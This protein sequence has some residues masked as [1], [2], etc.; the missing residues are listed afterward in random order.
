MPAY[1]GPWRVVSAEPV[2][3]ELLGL[4]RKLV[5][6]MLEV[7]GIPQR[8]WRL[9]DGTTIHAL[10]VNGMPKVTITHS[11]HGVVRE[12][13]DADLWLP[14]GFVVY[15]AWA[16][17]PYGVGLP[18]VPS[19]DPAVG[20]YDAANL[21]PG[22][23]RA[24]WTAGGPCGEVL[25]SMDE[26]AG[27]PQ[28]LT[29]PVPLMSDPLLGPVFRW[30]GRGSYDDRP[31]RS[32]WTSYRLELAPLVQHYSE[33]NV[34][35]GL[36]LFE[37]VN[38]ARTAAS[39]TPAVLRFRGYARPAEI[40]ASICFTAG[41]DD[42]TSTSYPLA[43]RHSYDRL[44][45]EGYAADVIGVPFVSFNRSDLFGMVEFR[46]ASGAPAD[47]VAAWASAPGSTLTSDL[48]R[49]V[50]ADVGY[51]GGFSA[52]ALSKVDRWIHAGNMNWQSSDVDLPALS[53]H[54]FAGLNLAW[55]TYPASYD[56]ANYTTTPLA[57]VRSF[58]DAQ[59]DCWLTYPRSTSPQTCDTEP[60]LGRHIYSRGRAIAMAP[61]GG[62]VWGACVTV[63]T[64][65][66][67]DVDRLIA[68]VHHPEEQPT[69]YTHEGFTRYLRVWWAD[70]PRRAGLRLAPEL[71]IAGE[72]AADPW[73]WHGGQ[74]IDVGMMS[75]PS[76]P[77]LAASTGVNSLKYA[78]QW[79]F[80]ADGLR[81]VCLRDYGA[82]VDYADLRGQAW[83]AA[84]LARAVELVFDTTADDLTTT[85]V[86]HDLTPGAS[87]AP[88][89]LTAL[90]NVGD[91]FSIPIYEMG[92]VPVAVDYTPD[93][94]LVYAYSAHVV[95][96][97]AAIYSPTDG[98][99]GFAE[100]IDYAYIG[101]GTA[102][103]KYMLDLSQRALHGARFQ[104]PTINLSHEL[105]V[106]LD[107]ATATFALKQTRP[108]FNINPS[109]PSTVSLVPSYPCQTFTA[110]AV[111][112]VRLARGG[113]IVS[114]AW[115]AA[116]DGAVWSVNDLCYPTS[117]DVT[118]LVYLPL[119]ASG[120][121]QG[122][123]AERHG[124]SVYGYQCS[125]IPKAVPALAAPPSASPCGCT[126]T[127]GDV[128]GA[129]YLTN[130]AL[131]P[132]GGRTVANV[133]LPDHDWLI[134]SKVV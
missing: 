2:P 111:N 5:G 129:P 33:E 130:A 87:A 55:E 48:G 17:Y 3:P 1:F 115:F 71:V 88:R 127:P 118:A 81:A 116:P 56:T 53:W 23:D 96:Q 107:V 94:A 13:A 40:A 16:G 124:R 28:A 31:A 125:P 123:Y 75:A 113:D 24:R 63:V 67:G 82:L 34:A 122:F 60:A 66:T 126:L 117:A 8:Q 12:V 133:P 61:R 114:E 109:S 90:P 76:D 65:A 103:V 39:Q 112:G 36:A 32:A 7:G 58:T 43:Y 57:P 83:S 79:R 27:Y 106:V 25:V 10:I 74:Q 84:R 121:V 62:L 64:T 29:V 120:H 128:A 73:A 30:A 72:D 42:E 134:Y 46:A 22:L 80:A 51:R 14:R 45:K 4:A 54:G 15:P 105:A 68:V 104:S 38:A 26:Q 9:D 131:N 99:A 37:A 11:V 77:T 89:A 101:T 35:T 92:A 132:R 69:D 86:F 95:S 93:G 21:S 20:P 85:V 110:G 52:L 41:T 18:I 6:G 108:R 70:I 98:S 50:V 44:T 49:A 78:S 102:A 100:Y 59:G 47:V 91:V 119:A 19:T 97:Q